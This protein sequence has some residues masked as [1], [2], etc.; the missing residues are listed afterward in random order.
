MSRYFESKEV[1]DGWFHT[2]DTGYIRDDGRVCILGRKKELII[3]G[4]FNIYPGEIERYLMANEFIEMASVFGISDKIFGEK[5][6]ASVVLSK[7]GV[8]GGEDII[9]YCRKS[10]AVYKIPDYITFNESF[11]LTVS[12]KIK[13]DKLKS[14]VLNEM[15]SG[16]NTLTIFEKLRQ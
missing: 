2:G 15:S 14:M 6:V 11:P 16:K 10:L 4:G 12:S 1:V 3:R 9:E 13:K 8:L 5:I 7:K